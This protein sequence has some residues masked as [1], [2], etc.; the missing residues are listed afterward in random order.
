MKARGPRPFGEQ[1]AVTAEKGDSGS[2][3]AEKK[4]GLARKLV[5]GVTRGSGTGMVWVGIRSPLVLHQSSRKSDVRGT[6]GEGRGR[7]VWPPFYGRG[8]GRSRE[9]G[10]PPRRGKKGGSSP[11]GKKGLFTLENQATPVAP[12][13]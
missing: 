9:R 2:P 10:R 8:P 11:Q 6:R 1:K 4:A 12:S 13:H 7:K 3:T 5:V